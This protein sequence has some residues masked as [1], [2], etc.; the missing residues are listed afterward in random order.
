MTLTTKYLGWTFQQWASACEWYLRIY[1]NGPSNPPDIQSRWK[2][3]R[4]SEPCDVNGGNAPVPRAF[5]AARDL[6]NKHVPS[7]AGR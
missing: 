4:T 2:Q 7:K 6:W 1:P 5:K 3:H